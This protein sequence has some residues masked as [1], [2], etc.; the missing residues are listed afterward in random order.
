[1]TGSPP[2]A[3]SWCGFLTVK[4]CDQSLK[5]DIFAGV[6]TPATVFLE[7]HDITYQAHPYDHD[8]GAASFG[9][10]AAEKLG[11]PPEAC[12]VIEDSANG[13]KTGV[14][15]GMRIW[16]FTGAGHRDEGLSARLIAAGA[17]AVFDD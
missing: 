9:I 3:V 10:E 11:L 8:P 13:A 7:S 2:V 5:N 1:M 16:G 4:R 15:A 14:A 6:Q 12:T 17:D